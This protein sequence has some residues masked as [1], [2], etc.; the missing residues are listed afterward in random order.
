MQPFGDQSPRQQPAGPPI[1]RVDSLDGM[2]ARPPQRSFPVRGQQQRPVFARQPV[3]QPG[4][5]A[6][7]I[8]VQMQVLAPV[9]NSVGKDEVVLALAGPTPQAPAA[10]QAPVTPLIFAPPVKTPIGEP[11]KPKR[12]KMPSIAWHKLAQKRVIVPASAA[13]S[14]ALLGWGVYAG[15]RYIQ[16]QGSPETIYKTAL[17]HA[18][19]TQQVQITMQSP[20]SQSVT[21]LD[22]TALKSP[23]ISSAGTTVIAG[24]KF[25]IRSYGSSSDSYVSYSSVPTGVATSTANAVQNKWVQLRRAGQLPAAINAPLSNAADPR[26]QTLGPMLFANTSK[27]TS[28]TIASFLVAHHVF[29]YDPLKVSKVPLN[30]TKVLLYQGKF[31]A[32]YAR[33]ANRSVAT[34]MGFSMPDIQRALDALNPYKGATSKLYVDP[35]GRK[36]V[37]LE[38]TTSGGQTTSYDFTGRASLPSQPSSNIDWP[39]FASTQLQLEAQASATAAPALRDS[40]RQTNLATMQSTLKLY[41]AKNG[42][43]PSLANLNDQSW[44]AS[45]LP[46]FD[47]DTTRDPLSSSLGLLASAPVAIPAVAKGKVAAKPAAPVT[48]TPIYGYIYQP[49]TAIGKSCANDP[50]TPP[51]QQCAQYTLTA[52]LTTGKPFI[53]T[54]TN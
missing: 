34:S 20:D 11:P 27:E 46:S 26:Y 1:R 10:S 36:V 7:A 25:G 42:V 33:I 47:P 28:Q 51:D 52:T 31:D 6:A 8:P 45:N 44:I 23:R 2:A 35:N 32:D 38:L 14:L 54:S 40:L 49:L 53:L 4:P 19:S 9:A 15:V 29:G 17:V 24:M 50:T 43:Y 18:L 12:L 16:T 21:Q 5:V 37:R 22:L 41:Y 3:P 39:Q 13:L 48:A 30:G